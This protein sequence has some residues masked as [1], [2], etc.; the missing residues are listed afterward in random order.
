MVMNYSEVESKVREA[1][2]DETW[3]P[4]G[5]LMAEIAKYTYTY[6]HYPEVMTML[7]RRMFEAKKNWRR[8]YKVKRKEGGRKQGWRKLYAVGFFVAWQPFTPG[9]VGNLVCVCSLYLS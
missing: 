6:E 8:T 3:G 9:G 1:T 2:N 4:H 5:S 7:W